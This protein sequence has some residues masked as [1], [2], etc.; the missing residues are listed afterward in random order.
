MNKSPDKTDRRVSLFPLS[1]EDA[2]RSLVRVKPKPEERQ[3]KG[4]ARE[5]EKRGGGESNPR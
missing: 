1:F 2:V 5:S 4:K 3:K